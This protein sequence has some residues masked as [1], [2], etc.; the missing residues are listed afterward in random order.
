MSLPKKHLQVEGRKEGDRIIVWVGN[1]TSV[2][3]I[4]C[5]V[6]GEDM[7]AC[8]NWKSRVWHKDSW[9]KEGRR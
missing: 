4:W 7:P 9:L 8:I 6:A 2:T 1:S 5:D 3:V